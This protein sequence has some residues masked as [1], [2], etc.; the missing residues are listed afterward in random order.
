MSKS[1]ILRSGSI[2]KKEDAARLIL[3]EDILFP[4]EV[5]EV[6]G[7]SYSEEQLKQLAAML[8][9][10]EVFRSLGKSNYA[11]MPAPPIPMSF[12]DVCEMKFDISGKWY[13]DE[14]FAMNDKTIFGWLAICKDIVPKSMGKNWKEQCRLLGSE[15]RVPNAAEFAWFITTYYEVRDVKLF[16][17]ILRELHLCPATTAFASAA[18]ARTA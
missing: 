8:P 18:G 16:G 17:N 1:H 14:N 3:G 6:R 4:D 11:L 13:A 7:L 15:E 5:V 12:L 9:S 10:E 2:F